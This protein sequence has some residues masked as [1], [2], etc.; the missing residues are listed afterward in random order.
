VPIHATGPYRVP[1]VRT[2]GRAYFTN[3]PPAGAF[4]GF[5]VPQSAIAHEAMMDMLADRMGHDRL[6]F[7]RRNALRAGDYTATGQKLEHS[8]GLVACLDALEPHW[9][10]ARKDVADFNAGSDIR[11]RGVGIGCMW[12]GIGNTS[13]T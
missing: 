1:A 4:R 12:Y 7:R 9:R 2:S 3:E 5:G 6:E 10:R 11:R 13:M 8:A